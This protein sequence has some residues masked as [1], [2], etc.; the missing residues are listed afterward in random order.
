VVNAI[1]VNATAFSVSATPPDTRT[2][3]ESYLLVRDVAVAPFGTQYGDG[4]ALAGMVSPGRPVAL[5]ENDGV[6]V[7]GASPPDAFDR[8]EVLEAT[9]EA[10]I[11]GRAFGEVQRMGDE[12]VAELVR[13]FAPPG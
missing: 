10:V 11:N 4:E 7:V 13:A 9:A 12:A 1:P 3:Q 5:L 2:I 6:M 8:L